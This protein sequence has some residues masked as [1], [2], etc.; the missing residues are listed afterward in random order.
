MY[1]T[2]KTVKRYFF[3]LGDRILFMPFQT[4]YFSIHDSKCALF[5]LFL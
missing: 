1:C 5:N 3:S 4:R 2:V